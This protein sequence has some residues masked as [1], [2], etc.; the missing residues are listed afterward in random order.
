M[1]YPEACLERDQRAASGARKK[2][3][4]LFLV[5]TNDRVLVDPF[6]EL[7]AGNWKVPLIFGFLEKKNKLPLAQ[8]V[9]FKVT[10]F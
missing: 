8:L 3:R 1:E 5:E 4:S 7:V 2:T 10:T 9:A 6:I